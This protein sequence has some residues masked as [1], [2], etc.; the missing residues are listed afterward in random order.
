MASSWARRAKPSA[1]APTVERKNVQ[2]RHRDLEP[3]AGIAQQIRRGHA[4]VGELQ[5]AQR[6]RGDDVEAFGYLE[7]R[8]IRVDDQRG[9]ALCAGCVL[10][11]AENDVLMRQPAVGNK[12]LFAVEHVMIAVEARIRGHRGHIGSRFRLR[13][14]EG[15]DA[16]AAGDLRQVPATDIFRAEQRDRPG[17]QPLHDEREIGHAGILR[18]GLPHQAQSPDVEGF[19]LAAPRCGNRILQPAAVGETFHQLARQRVE[20]G[21]VVRFLFRQ[22]R[23]FT[24]GPGPEFPRQIAVGLFQERPVQIG[25][26]GHRI[27]FLR[28]RVSASRRKRRRRAG[29]PVSACRW[30][31]LRPRP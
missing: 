18:Q 3:V 22:G 19:V 8:Q 25:L 11:P 6:V 10:R 26:F 1:A 16:I 24:V 29:S 2:R 27:S 20:T 7:A 21:L 15:G 23:D 28:T 12:R 17:A 14:G 13:Q 9:Q 4:A 31:V 5:P 30:P